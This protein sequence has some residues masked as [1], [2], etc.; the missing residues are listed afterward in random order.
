MSSTIIT[1]RSGERFQARE[2]ADR[3]SSQI[4]TGRLEDKLVRIE[5]YSTPTGKVVY[6]DPNAV[7]SVR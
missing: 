5:L 6:L 1:M 7:E 3:V 2:S 4:N